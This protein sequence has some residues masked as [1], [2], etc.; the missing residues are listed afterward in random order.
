[1]SILIL[2]V[3]IF[4]MTF[5]GSMGA[6]FLKKGTS[7][8][9]KLSIL[10]MLKTPELYAGGVLYVLGACTNIVLLRS[11]PYTVVYPMTSLTYVWTMFVSAILLKEKITRNKVL[12]VV[13][14]A[15]GI[16]FISM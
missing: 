13:F 3:M 10:E 14:I 7:K 11:M 8:M 5:S 2:I 9:Q 4:A 16:C 1:M 15:V 6:F 12:A